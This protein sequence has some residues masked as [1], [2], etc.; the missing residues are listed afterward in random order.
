MTA[1]SM[2]CGTEFENFRPPCLQASLYC[3]RRKGRNYNIGIG[4][5]T[6]RSSLAAIGHSKI[7]TWNARKDVLQANN[8]QRSTDILRERLHDKIPGSDNQ[9][10]HLPQ[11]SCWRMYFNSVLQSKL[12]WTRIQLFPLWVTS[13]HTL[14]GNDNISALGYVLPEDVFTTLFIR[15]LIEII[16]QPSELSEEPLFTEIAAQ[17]WFEFVYGSW[18]DQRHWTSLAIFNTAVELFE[19]YQFRFSVFLYKPTNS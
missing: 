18:R 15:E 10:W 4:M 2:P 6:L 16:L 7:R 19:W 8:A 9:A 11:G 13:F 5:E 17:A 12:Y 1:Q 14:T 3:M